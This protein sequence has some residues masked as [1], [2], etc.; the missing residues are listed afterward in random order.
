MELRDCQPETLNL[1]QVSNTSKG[2]HL[3]GGYVSIWGVG[4][5]RE[6]RGDNINVKIL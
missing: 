5:R 2:P 6:G 1:V 3:S 4:G